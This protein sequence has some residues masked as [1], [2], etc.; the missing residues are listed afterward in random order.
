M[1]AAGARVEA[2]FTWQRSA[3]CLAGVLAHRIGRLTE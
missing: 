2:E 1:G 3:E